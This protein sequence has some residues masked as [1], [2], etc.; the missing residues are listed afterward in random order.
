[1][2]KYYNILT[3]NVKPLD[4]SIPCITNDTLYI[5]V[6][7]AGSD[8]NGEV[9][10]ITS[11]KIHFKIDDCLFNKKQ[12][13]VRVFVRVGCGVKVFTAQNSMSMV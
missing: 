3:Y 1:M 6:C 5:V 8:T 10:F 2:D 7:G 9:F 11:F 13:I 12:V 4:Q